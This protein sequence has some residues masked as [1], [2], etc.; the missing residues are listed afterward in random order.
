MFKQLYKKIKKITNLIVLA[1]KQFFY[2]TKQQTMLFL[3]QNFNFMPFKKNYMKIR[4]I[5]LTLF[6]KELDKIL[7]KKHHL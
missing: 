3:A 5:Y 1:K 7:K 6:W 2:N 4:L